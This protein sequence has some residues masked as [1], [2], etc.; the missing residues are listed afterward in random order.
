MKIKEIEI[1]LFKKGLNYIMVD[2][3][4]DLPWN[5]TRLTVSKPHKKGEEILSKVLNKSLHEIFPDRY[6]ENN[7]R[8]KKLNYSY[9]TLK[10]DNMQ[11]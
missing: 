3:M 11:C 4:Y 5:T 2:K 10:E 8:F 6:D 7:K 9:K 1:A